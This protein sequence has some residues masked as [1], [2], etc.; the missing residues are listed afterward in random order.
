MLVAALPTKSARPMCSGTPAPANTTLHVAP[1]SALRAMVWPPPP[2]STVLPSHHTLFQAAP[3][4][5]PMLH[6][7]PPSVLRQTVRLPT[8]TQVVGDTAQR[9]T[10]GFAVIVG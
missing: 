6:V 9:S 4:S 5:A 2:A 1:P 3:A 10:M 7:A 8:A